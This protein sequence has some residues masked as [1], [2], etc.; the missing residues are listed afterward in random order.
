MIA[1]EMRIGFARWDTA[2]WS[3]IAIKSSLYPKKEIRNMR[4]KWNILAACSLIIALAI[5]L[6]TYVLF[7]HMMPNGS[8]V[9]AYQT[10]PAKP[11]IT[12]L[13]GIWGVM[14]LFAAVISWVI[15]K[16]FYPKK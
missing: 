11:F 12:L 9:A 7:H 13:F 16:I 6:F 15:G 1:A 5:F 14:F 8:F 3:G 10:A 2:D 4:K